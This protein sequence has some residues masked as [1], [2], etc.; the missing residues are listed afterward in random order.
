MSNGADT[1]TKSARPSLAAAWWLA[2]RPRTL[3]IAVVPVLLGAAL[4]LAGGHSLNVGVFLITLVAAMLIQIGTNLD[5]DVGDFERGTDGAGRLGPPRATS[6][7]WLTAGQ[8]R[9]AV[10]ITF[11]VSC[12]LGA[13]LAWYGGWPILL[14]GVLSVIAGVAYTSGPKPIAY[15][16]FGELFVWV[17]FGVVAVAGTYYLQVFAISDAAI[18]LG[19]IVGLH[20][21]AVLVVN[22]YRDA[23][24]DRKSG[25]HT[26][27]VRLGRDFT[28]WEYL[29]LVIAPFALLPLLAAQTGRA[30]VLALPLAAAPV[31]AA[32]LR[33]FWREPIGPAFNRLLGQT[34]MLQ[35]IFGMLLAVAL[36]L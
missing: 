5:N 13:Y 2:A 17:F 11:G 1:A 29:A 8:V 12:A 16:G 14:I 20:A 27:A 21:A 9:T 33:R 3:T 26:L 32:L 23:D 34:A 24:S 25:K 22:N 30:L 6:Q 35:M 28:R 10:T 36:L 4:A 7:G 15:T 19:A 18:T 31:A